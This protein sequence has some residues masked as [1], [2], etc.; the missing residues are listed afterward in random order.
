MPKQHAADPPVPS[1][2]WRR[3]AGAVLATR[4]FAVAAALLSLAVFAGCSTLDSQQR[5]WIFQPAASTPWAGEAA[6]TGMDTVW[7]DFDSQASGQPA[8]LH[9]LWLANPDADAPVLLYLHG[10]RWDVTGSA[11]RI[12]RMQALGFSVLAID[13]RGFGKSDTLLP[14][15][16]T[17]REDAHAAWDWLAARHP[18]RPR[19]VFGHS[20]GGAIAIALASETRDEAGLIVENTF[21]SIADVLA[22]M[23]WGWLPISPLI[24]QRFESAERIAAVGA[25]TLVVHGSA[26]TLIPAALGRR[27]YARASGR[28]RWLLVEGGT[29]H[30]TNVRGQAA[31]REALAELFGIGHDAG[32]ATR[33]VVQSDHDDHAQAQEAGRTAVR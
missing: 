33:R 29:H 5:R 16:T 6:I 32:D 31:Y 22:G 20:L 25:P 3:F 17:A 24:T 7:I 1:R 21:T 11:S 12:R 26:D 8:R 23:R 14:S 30:D 19:Y 28:K 13:Y 15:E 2:P 18:G 9:A 27:L 10:A 4:R